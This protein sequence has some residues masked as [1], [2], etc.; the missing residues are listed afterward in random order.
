MSLAVIEQ[1]KKRVFQSRFLS[2]DERQ[3]LKDGL[4]LLKNLKGQEFDHISDYSFLVAPFAKAYEGF[5]KDVFLKMGLITSEEY[6]SDHF[7]VGKVLNPNLH[8]KSF[9]V[10]SRLANLGKQGESLAQQLWLAWKKGRN[11]IFHYFSH[12][13]NKLSF[14]EAEARVE[15]I[16]RAMIAADFLLDKESKD[17]DN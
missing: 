3:L 9:S 2:S 12:N 7:R 14:A 1:L 11:L 4:L 6:F 13:L 10:Y 15:Q 17:K 5:L 16:L 8:K